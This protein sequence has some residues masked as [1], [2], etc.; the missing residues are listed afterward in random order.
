MREFCQGGPRL[1]ISL[2]RDITERKRAAE[3][4]RERQGELTHANRV[5]TMGQLT[6]SVAH[7]VSQP[8]AATLTNA[9]A[10]L[11][12]LSSQPPNLEEVRQTLDHII[13][14]AKRGGEVMNQIRALIRKAPARKDSID[15]NNTILDV[16]ALTRSEALRHGVHYRPTLR[17][18]CRSS[19]AIASSCNRSFST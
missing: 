6:A 4:F 3:A 19:K 12:W 1:F 2:S 5:A 10:A 16:I 14:D 15:I 11:R 17:P 18:A 8:I 7:E 13:N 9:Q